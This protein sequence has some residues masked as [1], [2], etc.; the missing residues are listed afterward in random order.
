LK[1]LF[2]TTSEDKIVFIL[3]RKP[4]WGLVLFIGLWLIF[5]L[6]CLGTIFIGLIEDA[7]K[8]N[9]EIYFYFSI[10]VI[11]GL[12]IVKVFLWLLWGKEKITLDENNLTVE[13]IG[14]FFTSARKYETSLI[15]NISI[16]TKHTT[17]GW[18]RLYG[19]GGGQVM[20]DY[21]EQK[22]YFGQ[23]LTHE[24]ANE[25]VGRFKEYLNKFRDN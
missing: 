12:W 5:W 6:A 20:F 22:K 8:R 15:D 11:L 24:E 2:A 3:K 9:A 17:P 25:I 14:T 23:T 18:Y 1:N 21:L 13:R 7:P 16:A 4:N 19:F 10:V